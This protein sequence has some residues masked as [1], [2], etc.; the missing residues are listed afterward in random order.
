LEEF[1]TAV[2]RKE[3]QR[4]DHQ[5]FMRCL[6]RKRHPGM[7][8]CNVKVL[9]SFVRV[10]SGRIV[11]RFGYTKTVLSVYIVMARFPVSTAPPAT[12]T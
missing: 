7:A 5:K 3:D 8:A 4:E 6:E 9:S 1:P 11:V 12:S 10:P 2:L